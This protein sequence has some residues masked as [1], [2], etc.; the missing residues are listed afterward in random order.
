M[1]IYPSQCHLMRKISLILWRDH[2][3]KKWRHFSHL[4]PG[5][6][7]KSRHSLVRWGKN[8]NRTFCHRHYNRFA[9]RCFNHMTI[10]S[11]FSQF[12]WTLHLLNFRNCCHLFIVFVK[13]EWIN[14]ATINKF[15]FLLF[16]IFAVLLQ[17]SSRSSLSNLVLKA[18]LPSRGLQGRRGTSWTG[19]VGKKSHY[20]GWEAA[21]NCL[22]I[23]LLDGNFKG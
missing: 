2:R 17:R 11:S 6:L 16:K 3:T 19:W 15:I 23:D 22:L 18:P 13:I 20:I 9:D 21:S 8:S 5:L 10:M 7:I 14:K 1:K 4:C 12:Y